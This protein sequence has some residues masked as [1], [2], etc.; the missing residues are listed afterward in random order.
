MSSDQCEDVYKKKGF[1]SIK[2]D[3]KSFES[4]NQAA[5]YLMSN[6]IILLS[7]K[8]HNG[9][10]IIFLVNEQIIDLIFPKLV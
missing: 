4:K 5:D 9:D 6:I 2:N 10:E 8:F 1:V 7:E 3:F